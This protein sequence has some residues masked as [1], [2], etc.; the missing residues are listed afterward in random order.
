MLALVSVLSSVGC[1]SW[2]ER[3][4]PPKYGDTPTDTFPS[5]LGRVPRNIVMISIDTF[6]RDHLD[7]YGEPGVTPFLSTLA[8]RGV[9]LDDLIQCSNWTYASTSCTLAGR[10]NFEA[11]LAAQLQELGREAWPEGTPFLA[12]HLA[13]AGYFSV[14]SSTNGWLS[15]EWGNTQ[16][17]TEAFH[18]HDGTALGAYREARA[19]LDEALA[20][21]ADR[22][23]LHV[24]MVEPHAP[25]APPD[26]YLGELAGLPPV[27][28][29]LS[30]QEV[31]YDQ[32]SNW[33]SMTPEEQDLLRSHLQ[34]RYR[35]ELRW[36]D[37]QIFTIYQDLEAD[38]LLDDAM[39][40]V[41]TDHGE[42][43]WEH[44]FQTHAYTL[45]PEENRS[46]G[47]FWAKNIVEAS[48]D[49][50]AS[51]IDLAP[52]LLSLQGL[53]IPPEMTGTPIGQAPPDR[54]R[55]AWAVAR[56][57][58]LQSITQGDWKLT[59]AWS[60]G[61]RLYDLSVDPQEQSNLYD[62]LDPDP[63]ALQLWAELEPAV[64]E[65][66]PLAPAYGVR[67]PTELFADPP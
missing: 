44:S 5:F 42:A 33:P 8:A 21:G 32:R 54:S 36:L 14:L 52:T 4:P 67:W 23:L 6:R 27:P 3:P 56:L 64:R 17:Y 46:I 35:A 13:E 63:I 25:Y 11:G 15:P 20:N 62:P 66:A 55:L 65:A 41:W 48:Y 47:F 49:G 60:G 16:G 7:R 1:T 18:P 2:P 43:F 19:S 31:H 26:S 30:D 58:S 50:P 38:D 45:H 37:D 57:G 22:W 24:H 9:A 12:T 34:A 40:V 10:Y 39:I 28:W 59:F 29:D 51:S 53:P 61:V